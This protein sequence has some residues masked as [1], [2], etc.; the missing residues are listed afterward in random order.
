MQ[1]TKKILAGSDEA[2]RGPLAGAVVAAAVILDPNN[3]IVGLK[4]SKKLSEKK[5]EILFDEIVEKSISYCIASA[6]V[7]E[8]D[9]LNILYASMLAMKRSIEGLDIQPTYV[10]VDGNRCPDI[11]YPCEAIVQGDD[12]V[13]EISAASILAKVTR[14]RQ[15]LK[16][17]KK[18]PAYGFAKHKGYPTKVHREILEK[19]GATQEHRRSFMLVKKALI[20]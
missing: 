17:D 16:M 7:Q 14:D 4:D 9:N 19:L 12:K 11:S 2:G 13:P 3:P 5:R 20:L 8:I 1:D 10:E 18:Y 15:M 6:S